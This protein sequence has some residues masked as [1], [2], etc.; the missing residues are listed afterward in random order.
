MLDLLSLSNARLAARRM[1]VHFLPSNSM[2]VYLK[3][4][5][6]TNI[7]MKLVLRKRGGSYPEKDYTT[8]E[9]TKKMIF[10]YVFT[11]PQGN[12]LKHYAKEREEETLSLFQPGDS[13]TVTLQETMKKTP[14]GEK[15]IGFLSWSAPGDVS[16]ESKPQLRSN[17]AERTQQAKQDEYQEKQE[18]KGI[19]IGLQG[20]A[21][22]L[23][24]TLLAGRPNVTKQELASLSLDW[25]EAL[26][27][28]TYRRAS[29]RCSKSVETLATTAI[30]DYKP[31]ID[32]KDLPF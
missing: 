29:A 17:T 24:P 25:A 9:P 20:F 1:S 21:Q 19:A 7:P 6:Q 26:Y 28:E 22:Q 23:A 8:K 16:V 18:V 31:S 30:P 5:L 14:A 4:Q 11:D 15:R 2:S 10:L 13:V 12:E 32:P 3:K 27:D